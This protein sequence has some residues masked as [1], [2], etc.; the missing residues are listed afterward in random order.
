[1]LHK[2]CG[3]DPTANE[4]LGKLLPALVVLHYHCP[5]C[6]QYQIPLF[7]KMFSV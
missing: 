7:S 4:W 2:I 1:L 6:R 3:L 5:K